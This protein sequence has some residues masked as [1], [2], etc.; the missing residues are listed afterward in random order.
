MK[1]AQ[2][3]EFGNVVERL[4]NRAD[5]RKEFDAPSIKGLNI[6]ERGYRTT[7]NLIN[8]DQAYFNP[9]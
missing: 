9:Y 2:S 4:E 7:G 5:F 3:R 6:F 8:G 1:G